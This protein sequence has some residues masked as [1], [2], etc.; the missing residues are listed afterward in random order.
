MI[1][2]AFHKNSSLELV[3]VILQLKILAKNAHLV[4]TQSKVKVVLLL[5]IEQ[6]NLMI[7]KNLFKFEN[8]FCIK[9]SRYINSSQASRDPENKR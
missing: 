2:K 8:Y 4:L 7:S 1:I 5:I 6:R 9:S 3:E